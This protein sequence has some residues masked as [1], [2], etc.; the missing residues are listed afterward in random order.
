VLKTGTTITR[1]YDF[2]VTA[3]L[4]ATN[5]RADDCYAY[6]VSAV[7][8]TNVFFGV[9]NATCPPATIFCPCSVSGN[10]KCIYCEEQTSEAE[11]SKNCECPCECPLTSQP[12]CPDDKE[13]EGPKTTTSRDIPACDPLSAL[14]REETFS[15]LAPSAEE[16]LSA[17]G[18]HGP[19]PECF[20][21]RCG[22]L[23]SKYDCLEVA[24]CSWCEVE[25]EMDPEMSSPS[26]IPLSRPHCAR[27][28]VCHGGAVGAASPYA[29]YVRGK[30][31][32]ERGGSDALSEG[33][34]SPVG[35]IAGGI[36]V[37][38][39]FMAFSVFCYRKGG[40]GGGGG[41]GGGD[42]GGAREGHRDI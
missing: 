4:T 32:R 33:V 2:D 41:G 36:M 8:G 24:G 20:V 9:V 14:H 42:I 31:L 3:D 10:R 1:F 12:K 18:G 5:S 21:P 38:F 27:Q 19:V 22:D 6:A 7:P 26:F 25:L 15:T 30:L 17:A 39:L 13:K 37:F 35:S 40:C 23:S 11:A 29:A 34:A 28:H 16:T